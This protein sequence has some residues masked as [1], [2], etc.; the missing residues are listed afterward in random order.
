MA[1]LRHACTALLSALLFAAPAEAAESMEQVRE[2]VRANAPRSAVVLEVSL[3]TRDAKG[4]SAPTRLKLY[5][6]RLPDGEQRVLIRF[7][8]PEELEGSAMLLQ[9]LGDARPRVHI[10]LPDLGKPQQV[11]SREQLTRFLGR[12]DL[13]LEEIALLLDPVGDPK[14]RLLDGAKAVD[15]RPAWA[16][17]WRAAEGE[18]PHYVRTVTF[19][20]QRLCIPLRA[21][22]YEADA[23]APRVM[24]VDP[25]RVSREADSWIPR[26]LIFRDPKDDVVRSLRIDGVEVDVPLAP[27]LLSVE[28]LSAGHAAKP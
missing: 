10:Y 11:S 22:L 24:R 16:F 25:A 20:D 17:E 3:Q 1:A 27:S 8:A 5:W 13:G 6:R 18:H 19:V 23:D 7:S 9:G 21:E 12:A 14:L 2:C 15:G 26:E 4:E 28:A